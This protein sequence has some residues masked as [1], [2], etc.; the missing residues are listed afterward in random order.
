MP[1]PYVRYTVYL[2]SGILASGYVGGQAFFQ[3]LFF[4]AVTLFMTTVLCRKW[5]GPTLRSVVPGILGFVIVFGLGAIRSDQNDHRN[6][7]THL[8][9]LQGPI[10]YYSAKVTGGALHRKGYFRVGVF[11]HAVKTREGWQKTEANA[12]LYIKKD[13]LKNTLKDTLPLVINYGDQI[14]LKGSPR[15]VDGPS[16]PLAFDYQNYLARQ[17]IFYQH[18]VEKRDIIKYGASNTRNIFY[19]AIQVRK[20]VRDIIQGA[21]TGSRERSIV[22]S[23]LIGEKHGLGPQVKKLYSDVGAMHVLAVSGLHVG[24][25]YLLFSIMLGSL[26]NHKNGKWVF[27][28]ICLLALWFYALLTGLSTSVLR[29]VVMFTF[30]LLGDTLGRG[31]NTYNNIA[32]AAFVLLLF[33]PFYLFQVGFQLSFVAVTGIVYLQPKISSWFHFSNV[34]LNKV[35]GLTA[36]SLAAQLATFPISVYYFHQF[37]AYFWLTNLLVIPS[38]T[39]IIFFGVFVI[40]LGFLGVS[41][42]F[43]SMLLEKL[44]FF[45]NEALALINTLPFSSIRGLYLTGWDVILIYAGLLAL[46]LF[47]STLKVRYFY[48]GSFLFLLLSSLS[49]LHYFNTRKQQQIVFYDIDKACAVDFIQGREQNL[50]V[51]TNQKTAGLDLHFAIANYRVSRGLSTADLESPKTGFNVGEDEDYKFFRWG[52][53]VFLV[54]NTKFRFEE[55]HH[56]RIKVNYLLINNQAVRDFSKVKK[57]FEFDKVIITNLNPFRYASDLRDQCLRNQINVHSIPHDGALIENLGGMIK[58]D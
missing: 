54:L 10:T 32:M 29:A 7:P 27:L 9:G 20:M 37:P 45:T 14:L 55:G 24:I 11:I 40:C 28:A 3:V 22:L 53:L 56:T 26:K 44:V 36:V 35:W 5:L 34:I 12:L 1:Y 30:I 8:T 49:I 41:V 19:Y 17:N 47:F 46:I 58:L 18:F 52:N 15:L 16:N 4:I 43:F 21:I 23:L 31:A 39:L 2:I 25:V 6:G 13:S 42:A 50:L 38:A 57:H 33:D 51:M 48:L